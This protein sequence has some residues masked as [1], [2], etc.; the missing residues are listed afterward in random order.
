M[1]QAVFQPYHIYDPVEPAA[2]DPL[3]PYLQ[4]KKDILFCGKGRY[5]VEALEDEAYLLPAK[6]R[7]LFLLH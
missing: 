2:V 6:F 4:R 7:Q 1:V 5:Q 3:M